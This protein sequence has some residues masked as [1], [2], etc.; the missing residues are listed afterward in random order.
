VS[1]GSLRAYLRAADAIALPYLSTWWESSATARDAIASGRPVIASSALAFFDLGGAVFRT[2]AGFPLERSIELVLTQPELGAALAGDA[3]RIALRDAWPRVAER[4]LAIYAELRGAGDAQLRAGVVRERRSPVPPNVQSETAEPAPPR[5][6]I[7]LREHAS[8]TGGGDFVLASAIRDAVDPERARIALVEGA[9]PPED[10]DAAHLFNF[11]TF[12]LTRRLAEACIARGLPVVVSALYE[13]WPS[14]KLASEESVQRA[15]VRLGLPIT[16]DLEAFAR[17]HAG[18]LRAL[19]ET[20]RFL[21]AHARA[22]VASGESEAERLRRDFPGIRTRVV[23]TAVPPRGRGDRDA[24][25]RTFGAR[26]F[27]L[28][29]GRIEPRK[30]QLALLEALED[31]PVDVVLATGGI[32]YRD[33]YLEACRAFRRR[34]RTLYLPELSE[35]QLIGAYEAARVHVLPSWFELPGLVTLEA[36]SAGCAVVASDRGTLRDHLGDAIPYAPP[37]DPAALRRAIESADGWS[38]GEARRRVDALTPER[39]AER[40]AEI[41]QEVAGAPA[42]HRSKPIERPVGEARRAGGVGNAAG[43]ARVTIFTN[44]KNAIATIERCLSSVEQIDHPDVEHVIQDGGSTDGTLEVLRRYAARHPERVKLESRADSCAAEGFFRGLARC[45]GELVGTCAADEALLPSAASRAVAAF[46]E[47]PDAGAIYGDMV[48]IDAEGRETGAY[49]AAPA[50]DFVARYVC[51][52]LV[53]PFAA[54]FF[55]RRCLEAIDVR[56]HAWD[57][58]VGEFELW[59]RLGLRFPVHYVPGVVTRYGIA[60]TALTRQDSLSL[61]QVTPRLRLMRHL[62]ADPGALGPWRALAER[63][64]AGLHLW[65]VEGLIPLDALESAAAQLGEA[66]CH[67]PDRER[68]SSVLNTAFVH[69]RNLLDGGD[70]ARGLAWIELAIAHGVVFGGYH[71]ARARALVA[72][73]RADEALAALRCELEQSAGHAGALRLRREL[74]GHDRDAGELPEP[75]AQN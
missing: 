43:P 29:V 60:D 57:W 4:H 25:V 39:Q 62:F 20:G 65:M 40:W 35:A 41:Y 61:R 51:H 48:L 49:A 36:L 67:A 32:A 55:R 7:L 54:T 26:D 27:V 37:D 11:A 14:F 52:E 16:V 6:H 50:D 70:P 30:N 64:Y 3:R 47:R 9:P 45:S 58:G 28:C 23:P 19:L 69:G 10:S 8:R 53:P 12:G 17:M 73:G 31:S 5:I 15:R 24:F 66:M 13:D 21:A 59:V 72:L 63:A 74:L 22:V 68:L 56:G 46:A 44:C 18:E 1:E 42:A 2:S 38:Y 33:D 34:G 75:A 71:F